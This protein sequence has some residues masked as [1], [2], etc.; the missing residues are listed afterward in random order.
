MKLSK[1]ELKAF[2]E[3][4]LEDLLEIAPT[5]SHP[6]GDPS[7]KGEFETR[8]AKGF[9]EPK[10][11]ELPRRATTRPMEKGEDTPQ[12]FYKAMMTL[13]GQYRAA[14]GVENEERG[15]AVDLVTKVLQASQIT[16]VP[17]RESIMVW[18]RKA[19]AELNRI[20]PQTQTT[21]QTGRRVATTG[22]PPGSP[23]L[24]K[25]FEGKKK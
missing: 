11:S 20:L 4:A 18:L 14:G 6:M 1:T 12:G 10:R 13:A 7:G 24:T 22:G 19:M 8:T 3:E 2:I 15:L 16:D 25:Q 17:K 9:I 5:S 23:G 21:T